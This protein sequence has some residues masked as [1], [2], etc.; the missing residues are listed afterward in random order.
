MG[1]R[2]EQ[3]DSLLCTKIINQIL[4]VFKYRSD[5]QYYIDIIYENNEDKFKQ[6]IPFLFKSI[7]NAKLI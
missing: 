7:W 3:T 5:I 2:G 4:N 1:P 6:V